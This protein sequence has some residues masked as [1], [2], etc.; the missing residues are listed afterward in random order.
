MSPSFLPSFSSLLHRFP[1][2]YAIGCLISLSASLPII[3]FFVP[4]LFCFF[5]LSSRMGLSL[6]SYIIPR[7]RSFLP[8]WA[9]PWKVSLMGLMSCLELRLLPLQLLHKELLLRLLSPLLS[10]YPETRVLIL[11][12]LVRPLPFLSRHLLSKWESFL[13]LL[14]KLRL[15]LLPHPL[16]SP[17]VTL[18]QLYLK[19]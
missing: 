19:L 14:L 4:H 15:L 11:R 18:S 2:P 17:P 10:R 5:F 7:L 12:G 6:S 3:D 9:H 16:L 8:L 1:L 13:L